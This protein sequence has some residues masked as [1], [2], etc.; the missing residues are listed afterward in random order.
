MSRNF[1]RKE[2]MGVISRGIKNAFRNGIRTLS[3]VSIL[4]LTIGMALVM[5]LALK[6][7]D[8]K[9]ASV[10]S[11]V[12][13]TITASPAGVRGFEGGGTLLTDQNATDIESLAHVTTVVK[14][15]T[16]RL[17]NENTTSSG[18]FPGGNSS[19]NSTTNLTS[20]IEAGSFGNR[21][22]SF[23]NQSSS[24]DSTTAQTF[25]M[26]ISVTGV[27]DLSSAALSVSQFDVT[28]GQKFDA[29]SSENVAMVGKDLA[30]KNNLS[31]DSTFTAYGKTIKVVGIYDTGNTFTNGAIVFP[32]KTVQTLSS[33]LG[34]INS[35]IVSTDSLDNVSTV[36]TAIKDKLGN[37]VDVTSAQDSSQSAIAPLQNIK[38]ISLYSLIG[39]LV[40]GAVIILLTMMM[41]V[42]ER[43]REIGVLKA[44]GSSNLGVMSQFIAEALTLTLS[45][46]VLGMIIGFFA[47]NP[48]LKVLVNNSESSTNIVGIPGGGGMAGAGQAMM[49]IG[50]G[51]GNNLRDIQAV[52]NYQV[53]L[54]GLVAAIIIAII[55]SAIP[56]LIISKIRPA[57]VMRAE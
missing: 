53:I 48:I 11:S 54:Y 52:L 40:A 25:S 8:A 17:R 19:T 30:T 3:I 15:L 44:I 41:I 36:A 28:S 18:N 29:A 49:R 51:L 33:Q 24:S 56:A 34:Q 12:G 20:S 13:N 6:T 1:P 23:E 26:P 4:A 31:V 57:E 21:Q 7:V 55:G 46:A 42:R 47:A 5:L 45:G 38:T 2:N 43:R 22:R 37:S 10:K 35:I 39:A 32:I 50:G 9:I 16:D 27:S 14:T